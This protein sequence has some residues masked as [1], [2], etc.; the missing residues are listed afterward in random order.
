M[1]ATRKHTFTQIQALTT[2]LGFK[3]R[4]RA[5][6]SADERYGVTEVF[7]TV[8]VKLRVLQHAIWRDRQGATAVEYGLLVGLA[9]LGLAAGWGALGDLVQQIFEMLSDQTQAATPTP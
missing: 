9:A 8:A 2:C 5:A 1:V 4:L 3:W 6:Y 7:R